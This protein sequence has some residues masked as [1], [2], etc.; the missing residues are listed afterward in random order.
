MLG[1]VI[2][3]GSSTFNITN[4]ST[5][6]FQNNTVMYMSVDSLGGGALFINQDSNLVVNNANLN[7]YN[8]FAKNK[9]GGAI[10]S[11]ESH[12]NMIEHAYVQFINNSAISQGGAIYL[13][14]G[15][16]NI[17]N[18]SVLIFA[19]N[20]A[21]EGG[22]LYLSL[23]WSLNLG[24]NS[25]IQFKSNSATMAGGALY[26]TLPQYWPCFL[27][28]RKHSVLSR[29]EFESNTAST[30][31]GMHIYGGSTRSSFCTNVWFTLPYCGKD[32][33]NINI[34]FSPNLNNSLSPVSSDP[35]RVCLCDANG[36]PQCAELSKI[37]QNNIK[38]IPGEYIYSSSWSR[39]WCHNWMGLCK[40]A[41]RNK[42]LCPT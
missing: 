33:G 42:N 38:V 16:I 36:K 40:D 35:K 6:I 10:L 28:V 1:L 20:S 4:Q 24:N 14:S 41:E 9:D 22:A 23:A 18:Q 12:I 29:V 8:N 2:Y 39:L 11:R 32:A 17:D 5:V 3:I 15:D 30:G 21:I 13:T 27:S 26:G 34:T 31:K 37:F 19:N 25:I 7:I